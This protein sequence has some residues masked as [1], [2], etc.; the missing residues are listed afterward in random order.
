MCYLTTLKGNYPKQ[1]ERLRRDGSSLLD[2]SQSSVNTCSF[3]EINDLSHIPSDWRSFL[4]DR[5][6]KRSLVNY[7]SASFLTLIPK[8][9][10]DSQSFTTAG[11]FDGEKKDKAFTCTKLETFE[12]ISF[13]SNHEEADS[14]H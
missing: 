13:K 7:L 3:W 10:N 9:I 1:V 14:M 12:N 5:K 6:S 4:A 11:G 8:F 2:A